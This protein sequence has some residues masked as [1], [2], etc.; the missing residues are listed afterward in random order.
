MIWIDTEVSMSSVP[1]NK[2]STKGKL[3]V[4]KMITSK[5]GHGSQPEK[6]VHELLHLY[7]SLV[8][9]WKKSETEELIADLGS[10][11]YGH[12]L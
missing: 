7:Q 3:F 9:K 5:S 8:H 11:T 6:C 4:I 1:F 10:Y 2:C 12:K